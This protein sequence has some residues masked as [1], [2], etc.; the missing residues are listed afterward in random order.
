MA[1]EQLGDRA[2]VVDACQIMVT[3]DG[4]FKPSMN[5]VAG[6]LRKAVSS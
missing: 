4:S 5:E 3:K 2:K 1:G 6:G